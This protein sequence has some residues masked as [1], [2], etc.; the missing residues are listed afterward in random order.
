[1]TPDQRDILTKFVGFTR[2]NM[3]PPR[4]VTDAVVACLEENAALQRLVKELTETRMVPSQGSLRQLDPDAE[5]LRAW[6]EQS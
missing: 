6:E 4:P 2:E 5:L 3:P 1:M